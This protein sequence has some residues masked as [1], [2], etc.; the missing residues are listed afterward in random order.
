MC[1]RL[2]VFVLAQFVNLLLQL[3]YRKAVLDHEVAEKF[4]NMRVFHSKQDF[5][6][7]GAEKP[8]LEVVL[9]FGRE[10]EKPQIIGH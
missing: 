4:L 7:S 9:D 2:C 6:V 5:R 1:G 10:F 8:G 3:A